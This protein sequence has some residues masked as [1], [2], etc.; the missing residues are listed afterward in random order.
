MGSDTRKYKQPRRLNA[1]SVVLLASLAAVG[2]VAFSAWP[3]VTLNADVKNVIEDALPRLYRANLLP[4]DEAT[5]GADQIRLDLI[6]KLTSLGVS[7]PE[8]ALTITRDAHVVAIA[9]R[10]TTAIDLKLL[11]RKIPLTLNPRV[12]TAAARV[13]Y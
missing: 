6:G 7:D 4:E 13:S 5:I 10:I 1:V 8:T 11:R 2:Y 9:T 3:V 12:E